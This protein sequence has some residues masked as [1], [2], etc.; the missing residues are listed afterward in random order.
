MAVSNLPVFFC[1]F[2][3]SSRSRLSSLRS[4]KTCFARS[5]TRRR[6]ISKWF[7]ADVHGWAATGTTHSDTD[8]DGE[9]R[10]HH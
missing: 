3:R 7:R 9:E 10:D 1:A 2:S 5:R 8:T 4:S 6:E